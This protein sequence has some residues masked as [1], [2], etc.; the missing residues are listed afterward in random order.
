MSFFIVS[1]ENRPLNYCEIMNPDQ[2]VS[3]IRVF[4]CFFLIPEQEILKVAS[5]RFWTNALH[6]K[7]NCCASRCFTRFLIVLHALLYLHNVSIFCIYVYLDTVL[8]DRKWP[9]EEDGNRN[10]EGSTSQV[11]NSGLTK[12]Y[13]ATWQKTKIIKTPCFH[14]RKVKCISLQ[15]KLKCWFFRSGFQMSHW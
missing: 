2:Q 4:I 1:G 10:R 3:F 15:I 8:T 13:R 6:F 9:D 7:M 11:S 14:E 12:C 5:Q